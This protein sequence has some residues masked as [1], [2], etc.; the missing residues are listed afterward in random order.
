MDVTI[1][2]GEFKAKCLQLID[3][4]AEH[5][6][7]VIITKRGQPVA[8]LIPFESDCASLIGSM[9]ARLKVRGNIS[10]TGVDWDAESGH[11]HP[12]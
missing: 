2:A 12:R 5:R 1:G 4:V 7:P 9:K 10:S 3:E 11:S 6:Q 8:R